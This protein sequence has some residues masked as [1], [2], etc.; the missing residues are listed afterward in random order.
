[1]DPT[2]AVYLLHFVPDGSS[3]T[4]YLLHFVQYGSSKNTHKYVFLH[5]HIEH[6]E[7]AENTPYMSP[8]TPHSYRLQARSM[9]NYERCTL[10]RT[11][12]LFC[13][14][15]V[16]FERAPPPGQL[17]GGPPPGLRGDFM[18]LFLWILVSILGARSGHVG[19][20]LGLSFIFVRFF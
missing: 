13:R 8:L 2:K 12:Y 4:G 3:N 6:R 18:Y 7:I 5:K 16:D 19:D 10:C 17:F 9:L 1:M 20:L 11:S 15:S 14:F